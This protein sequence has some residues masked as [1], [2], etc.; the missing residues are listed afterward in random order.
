VYAE[1]TRRHYINVRG[2]TSVLRRVSAV[3]YPAIALLT[4][5]N[6]FYS[7]YHRF[8]TVITEPTAPE[9]CHGRSQLLFWAICVIACRPRPDH[10]IVRAR[11]PEFAHNL[12]E[13]VRQ[14]VSGILMAPRWSLAA[15]QA[16]LLLSE[17]AYVGLCG[18]REEPHWV[19]RS[20]EAA[21]MH[22]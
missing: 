12:G 2:N 20:F 5:L 22:T 10:R 4:S 17:Y 6:R 7:H 3:L 15:I 13:H 1:N 16:L 8:V 9:A 18:G 21:P 19:G 14:L 11:D